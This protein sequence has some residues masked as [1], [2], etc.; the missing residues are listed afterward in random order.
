M[1]S[2]PQIK[3]SPYSNVAPIKPPSSDSNK[4]NMHLHNNNNN[5]ITNISSGNINPNIRGNSISNSIRA[6]PIN[7][8]LGG[9]V[10]QKRN[11]NHKDLYTFL[12]NNNTI[13]T[14]LAVKAIPFYNNQKSLKK[15]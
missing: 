1:I 12:G 2:L 13:G 6:I 10:N 7:Y 3:P 15:K 4:R 5:N 11:T 14:E 8:V 9:N